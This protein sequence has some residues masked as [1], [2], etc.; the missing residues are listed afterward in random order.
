M[1]QPVQRE[2]HPLHA[3][4]KIR[5]RAHA[6]EDQRIGAT[7]FGGVVEMRARVE[8]D[9]RQAAAFQFR[10]QRPEPVGM[11]VID[12][13]WLHSRALVAKIPNVLQRCIALR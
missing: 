5:R 12:R 4:A 11:F 8:P 13:D 7:L 3:A 2:E 6:V 9:E 10:E 1:G